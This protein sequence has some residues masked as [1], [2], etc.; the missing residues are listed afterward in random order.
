VRVVP[1]GPVASG[2]TLYD[3]ELV[4]GVRP[5]SHAGRSTQR[6]ASYVVAALWPEAATLA[7]QQLFLDDAGRVGLTVEPG[8]RVLRCVPADR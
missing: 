6:T 4:G 3:L 1:D 5:R 2:A 7:A 8:V